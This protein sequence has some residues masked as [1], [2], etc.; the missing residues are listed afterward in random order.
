MYFLNKLKEINEALYDEYL[1]KYLRVQKDYNKKQFIVFR[2][3]KQKGVH[4]YGD[5]FLF[6]KTLNNQEY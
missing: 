2:F 4:H 1:E 3:N 5:P 6:K